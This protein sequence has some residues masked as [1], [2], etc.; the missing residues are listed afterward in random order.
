EVYRSASVCDYYTPDLCGLTP[1]QGVQEI[2]K[3]STDAAELA[4]I[5]RSWRDQTR[6]IRKSYRRY[7]DLAN[8]A[9]HTNNL[10]N[11]VELE[12]GEY[13]GGGFRQDLQE[14]WQQLRPLYLQLHAYTRRKLRQVYGPQVV[15]ERGPLPA[16][17]LGDLWAQQWKVWDLIIPFPGK[18]NPNVTLEM[19]RQ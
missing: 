18:T 9:A 11:K 5:W 13:G 7:M 6:G 10:V 1:Q 16:H 17:L 2:F 14:A 12:L 19:K 8:L 4:Y 3:K 15:T